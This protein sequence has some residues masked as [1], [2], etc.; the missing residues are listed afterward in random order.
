VQASANSTSAS[1][2]G[3]APGESARPVG[4]GMI[5]FGT[6]GS[7]V[8][9]LLR[10]HADLYASRIGRRIVL[11]RV[12]VRDAGSRRPELDP[13]IVTDDPEAFF[14]TPEMDV[15]IEV[16]GGAAVR[17]LI[18]RAFERGC[19]V[20][21]ANKSLIA[22]SGD[23]L[24]ERAR[25]CGVSLAFEASCGGGIPIVTTLLFGL[26]ANRFDH[27]VGILNGTCN[28]ILSAMTE[29]GEAYEKAL[30]EAQRLGYAE[31]DPTL[32]I[33]GRDAAEKLAILASL[34]YGVHIDVDRDIFCEGVGGIE[35]SD[36]QLADELGYVMKLLAIAD[37]SDSGVCLAV[38]PCLLAQTQPLAKIGGSFNA[39][40]VLGSANGMT[41]YV[42]RGAGRMPTAS[43]VVSD[44]LN[45]VS[46]WYPL[47]FAEL[48]GRRYAGDAPPLTGNLSSRFYLRINTIDRPG[49]MAAITSVLASHGISISAAMQH[50]SAAGQ[51]VPVVV[52]TH[53][54][55]HEAIRPAVGELASLEVVHGEVVYFRIVDF[56]DEA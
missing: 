46:G 9:R 49:S 51:V 21:S 47:A 30:A 53:E 39:L 25:R 3:P 37:L 45:V 24:F 34:A 16:A 20:V 31:A 14:Q 55:D 38:E 28:F 10:E 52:T 50:E 15:V 36:I 5:G 7:G 12:L 35:L 17:P 8:A 42:G 32:D 56:P 1:A 18:E 22:A 4:V 40:S 26:Q 27:M 29:R 44:L 13:Q 11:R 23:A 43:A 19:H 41:T 33:S 6:V 54:A 48:V 2:S